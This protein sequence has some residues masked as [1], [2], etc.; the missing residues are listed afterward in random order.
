MKPT[1]NPLKEAVMMKTTLLALALVFVTGCDFNKPPTQENLGDINLASNVEFNLDARSQIDTSADPVVGKAVVS[2]TDSGT[3]LLEIA[4][5]PAGTYSVTATPTDTANYEQ[6]KFDLVVKFGDNPVTSVIFSKKG[7]SGNVDIDAL[8]EAI[9]KG[10]ADTVAKILAKL[11]EQKVAIDQLLKDQAK[12]I[13]Y[14]MKAK[15]TCL[16]KAQLP[17]AGCLIVETNFAY[18]DGDTRGCTTDVTGSCPIGFLPMNTP[19]RFTAKLASFM[20]QEVMKT[21]NTPAVLDLTFNMIPAGAAGDLIWV[22]GF[23]VDSGKT[24]DT[25]G[26][27]MEVQADGT[28]VVVTGA[29]GLKCTVKSGSEAYNM[30]L[31]CEVLTGLKPGCGIVEASLNGKK[32]TTP[33][34]VLGTGAPAT[35][36]AS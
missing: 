21:I 36:P 9:A 7:T 14:P 24:R 16:D 33:I 34:R 28:V 15:V 1:T 11:A 30:D 25:K 20:P 35:C 8:K 18:A 32:V 4:N 6:K 19:L 27:V 5:V 22:S 26:T 29:D 23:K 3:Y 31:A 12:A 10:D 2:T 13:I 17:L